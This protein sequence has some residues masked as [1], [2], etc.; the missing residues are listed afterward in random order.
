MSAYTESNSYDP[1]VSM[2]FGDMQQLYL[3]SASV[4]VAPA[5]GTDLDNPLYNPHLPI[6]PQISSQQYLVPQAQSL[7]TRP[8]NKKSKELVAM[9]LYD[10]AAQVQRES[11]GKTLKLEDSWQPPEK[12][13]EKQLM[14]EHSHI[15]GQEEDSSTDEDEEETLALPSTA[16]SHSHVPVYQDLSNQSFFFED[17]DSYTNLMPV[18]SELPMYQPKLPEDIQASFSWT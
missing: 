4:P 3:S 1:N 15:D 14:G 16:V 11:I 5:L 8:R 13:K 9:G 2:S 18:A 6:N 12:E 10:D 7:S 17:D